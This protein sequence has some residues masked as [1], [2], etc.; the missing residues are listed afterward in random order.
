MLH[1]PLNIS[2]RDHITNEDLYDHLPK[3]SDKIRERRMRVAG[4][5]IRHK[6]EEALK[7]VLWQPQHGQIKLGRPKS[8]YIHTL[9]DTKFATVGELRTV[10]LD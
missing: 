4:H 3:V 1:T 5:C 7:L 9:L 10:M 2:C 6:K 8:T